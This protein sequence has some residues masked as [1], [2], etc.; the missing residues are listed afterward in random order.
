MTNKLM[1]P[2]TQ[3]IRTADGSCTLYRED[4]DETYHSIH[5]AL[6]E[7]IHVYIDNGLARL[8]SEKDI[9]IL[10]IG[11]GTGLNALLTMDHAEE[12]QNI[13]YYSIEP[14]PVDAEI[15]M[16]YYKQ[17]AIKPINY[18]SLEKMLASNGS[19]VQIRPG[20][21]FCLLNKTLQS[22]QANDVK[23]IRFDLVYYDAFGPSKQAEMW[24][25]E[26]LKNAV[27]LMKTGGILTTYCSQGQFK[28]NLKSLGLQIENPKGPMGKREMTVGTKL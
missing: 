13:H 26:T 8:K 25:V 23:D 10:E 20:F 17:F 15:I 16:D 24:T 27:D 5:G 11:L 7:S 2:G 4:L 3:I 22:L 12:G 14:F 28:R 19:P 21:D 9:H 6:A 18:P 1:S